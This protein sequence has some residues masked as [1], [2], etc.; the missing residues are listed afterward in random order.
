MVTITPTIEP[1]VK[2][3]QAWQYLL[4]NET[5]ILCFGGGAGG[6]KTWLGS[7]WLLT[8]CYKYPK[9]RW[10]IARKKLKNII[11]TN[12][13]SFRKVC[14][15]HNIPPGDWSF[16]GQYSY[17][18]FKNG[19]RIDFID[20]SLQPSDPDYQ[21]L[22]STEFTGG[23]IEEAGE[24]AFKGFD[25]LKS[26]VGRTMNKEY[27]ILSKILLTC[28]PD[29]G[30]IKRM[31]YTP[32]TKGTLPKKY[33]F[34]QSLHKHNPFLADEYKENLRDM[35]DTKNRN[36]LYLG[37]WDFNDDLTILFD[38]N[39][40]YDVFT[41]TIDKSDRKYLIVDIA[42]E[43]QDTTVFSVWRGLEEYRREIEYGVSQT[44]NIIQ[45]IREICAEERI[46][47]SQVAVD[48]IGVGK[49]VAD[50]SLLRGVVGFKSS[51]APIKTDKDIITLPSHVGRVTKSP[52]EKYTTDFL[53]LRC[54][55]TFYLADLIN[56]HK[57]VSRIVD[58]VNIEEILEELRMYKDITVGDQ[59][60]RCTAKEDISDALG[61]SPDQSDTWVMRMYFEI[62][63]EM[64]PGVSEHS[65]R[66]K[67]R[68][69]ESFQR[70]MSNQK[71]DSTR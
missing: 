40:L 4:D 41:N 70:N 7:E 9:T 8:Q 16:N 39:A 64:L 14:D 57:M 3:H 68:Q 56:S 58:E 44:E 13:P 18:Q 53:N 63:N 48:A 66:A 33:K 45:R 55:C 36:R 23:W 21:D 35:S 69:E 65:M 49:G 51:Y 28:N 15:H 32:W 1:S 22:G 50:S 11:Q 27:G 20:L 6:G 26:R 67:K 17:I 29:E 12:L 71:L 19:S 10:F 2:Q 59:K 46:P 52:T 61:R 54:Q 42:G 25:V 5:K 62:K 24:V 37:S 34:I 30:F 38:R 43:G 31:F 60:R 47:Y